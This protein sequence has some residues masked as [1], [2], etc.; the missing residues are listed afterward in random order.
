M[1]GSSDFKVTENSLS[2]KLTKNKLGANYLNI[3]L[4]PMD[5]Y[6]MTFISVRNLKVTVKKELNDVYNRELKTRFTDVTGLYTNL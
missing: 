4:T 5:T 1:T 3:K 6:N 2:M